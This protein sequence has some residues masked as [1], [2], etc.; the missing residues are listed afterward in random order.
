MKKLLLAAISLLSA[1]A[2]HAIAPCAVCTVAVAAGL[3]T[4]RMM[5]VDDTITG[6]WAGALTLVLVFWT[7]KFLKR[8]GVTGGVWYFL[9]FATYYAL[10][11]GVYYFTDYIRW[12]WIFDKFIIGAVAGTLVM[13]AAEI[14]LSNSIAANGGKSRFK[15]QK[16]IVPLV[17]LAWLSG[18]FALVAYL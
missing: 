6:V 11:F 2:A 16:V 8:R 12:I 10:L 3:E 4:A 5:G 7:L 15:F 17:A 9:T 14:Q 1:S 18:I 13:W